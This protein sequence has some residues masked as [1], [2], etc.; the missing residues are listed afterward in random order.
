MIQDST[1]KPKAVSAIGV[2]A[3]VAA[4]SWIKRLESGGLPRPERMPQLRGGPL[5][6]LLAQKRKFIDGLL[7]CP[8]SLI[9]IKTVSQASKGRI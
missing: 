3:Q 6:P 2:C 7:D 9:S 8:N 4:G 1:R 5:S